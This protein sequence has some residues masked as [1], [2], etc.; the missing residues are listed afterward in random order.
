[1]TQISFFSR[2]LDLIVP[3]A[4]PS[5]E[6]RLAITE[7]PLCAACN[8]SL[9]RTMHHL[10]PFENEMARLFW[11][12]IPVEKCAAFF[13]YKPNST[14][15]YLIYKL[16]Y[17][18]HPEIGE[19]LGQLVATE[20]ESENFFD[21]ITALLPVPL[22][23]RRTIQRGYNQSIEIARG[24]SSV[25]GLPII[26]KAIRR[27]TFIE[28]QTHKDLWERYKNVEN[29]FEL[30]DAAK[31]NNQHVL[32]IDDVITSGATITAIGKELIKVPNI[33]IS[34][35]SLCFASDK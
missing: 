17:F 15:S 1:M 23:Y 34:V 29:T 22:T 24:I 10:Q 35:L 3:R 12:R 8:M 33:K 21:E 9:P 20:Y 13:L 7:G 19:Q 26:T 11:G 27:K 31:L 30:N 5:C 2:V 14:S 4:C 28:S 32:L 16:K 18:D 25:T 6:R